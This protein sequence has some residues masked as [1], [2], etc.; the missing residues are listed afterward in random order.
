MIGA[1]GGALRYEDTRTATVAECN[2]DDSSPGP[3]AQSLRLACRFP[4]IL[5]S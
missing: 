4:A 5:K 2:V 3:P 1:A